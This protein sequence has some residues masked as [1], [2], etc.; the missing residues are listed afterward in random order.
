[1][2]K[3]VF[4][5]VVFG[6]LVIAAPASAQVFIGADSGGAGV[7]L[8]PVGVGVGPR[9]SDD[10]YYHRRGY[11]ANAYHGGDCRLIRSRVVTPSGRVVVRTR[12]KAA[13]TAEEISAI[14]DLMVDLQK[15][16]QRL[17]GT[18]NRE[19]SGASGDVNEFVSDALNG[20]IARIRNGA[21]SVSSKATHL[22]SDVFKKISDE[23]E[24]RPFTMLAIAAGVGF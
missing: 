21:D 15:R 1:M 23:V 17:G 14:Q 8:G 3:L 10:S 11:D 12:S 4:G 9:F 19:F 16:L 13:S 6:V 20:I 7:Q 18:T 22:G 5:L 24:Q 2:N